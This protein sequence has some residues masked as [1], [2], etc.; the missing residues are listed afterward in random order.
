MSKMT[1]KG[2]SARIEYD[3]RDGI[4]VGRIVGIQDIISF[5]ADTVA[6]LKA[7]FI[8]AVDDY[9]ALCAETG[10]QPQKAYSGKL[11]LRVSAD[12]HAAAARAAELSGKSLNAWSEEVLRRGAETSTRRPRT[13]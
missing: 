7:A 11:M 5:P 9:L 3:D 10:R 6:D 2:Y 12:V 1:H 8:E 13:S 4:F